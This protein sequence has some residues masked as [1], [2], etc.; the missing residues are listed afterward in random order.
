[1]E[2]R[3][4]EGKYRRPLA[5]GRQVAAARCAAQA[6]VRAEP[7]EVRQ[8]KRQKTRERAAWTSAEMSAI[9]PLT[10]DEHHHR[11]RASAIRSAWNRQ[12]FVPFA[13]LVRRVQRSIDPPPPVLSTVPHY[14]KFEVESF[15]IRIQN[16]VHGQPFMLQIHTYGEAVRFGCPVRLVEFHAMPDAFHLAGDLA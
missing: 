15:P 1:M 10:C 7:P 4:F 16:D 3:Q 5:F 8:L 11:P 6:R 13:N 12:C 2:A 9:H 14:R